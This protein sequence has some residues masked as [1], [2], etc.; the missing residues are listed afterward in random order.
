MICALA[1][2]AVDTCTCCLGTCRT[3]C[4]TRVGQSR[5]SEISGMAYKFLPPMLPFVPIILP[6]APPCGLGRSPKWQI[7]FS[8]ASIRSNH[9]STSTT[10]WF[11]P[12]DTS[13]ARRRFAP[14]PPPPDP[15]PRLPTSVG[16]QKSP[17]LFNPSWPPDENASS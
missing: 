6:R 9:S 12:H 8:D 1:P 15:P 11:R 5:E 4:R 16:S 7:R 10:V 3:K 13:T 17:S 14:P 2:R